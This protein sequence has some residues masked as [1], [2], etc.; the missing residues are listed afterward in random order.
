MD[1]F[2]QS[3]S[4]IHHDTADPGGSGNNE[5]YHILVL[6]AYKNLYL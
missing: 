6:T 2:I 4:Y 5:K 1:T 3:N